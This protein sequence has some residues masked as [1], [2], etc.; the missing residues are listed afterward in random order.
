MN[1]RLFLGALMFAGAAGA[2]GAETALRT[3]PLQFAPG[4]SVATVK[5]SLRGDQTVDYVLQGR[6]G[7][8][9]RVHLAT[10][11]GANYFNVLPPDSESALFIGSTSGNDWQGMLPVDGEYRIRVYL[12]RSAA[13]RNETATYSLTVNQS[14]G[15]VDAKVPGTPFHATG[16]VPCSVGP[17]PKGSSQ[18]AFGV[19]RHGLGQAEVHVLP[20]GDVLGTH[21]DRAR[22]LKFSGNK[23]IPANP[24]ERAEAQLRGDIWS[25]TVNGFY[26]YEIPEAVI[27]GG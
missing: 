19:I 15:S 2:I 10:R 20:P 24:S 3:Q 25:V 12:M 17:D 1:M 7:Q 8:L 4:A 18:C 6:A 26:F 16:Q 21:T 22:I 23:V 11:H 13:R 9:L 5:G 27:N 14:P